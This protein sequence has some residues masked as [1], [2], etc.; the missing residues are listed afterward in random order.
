MR[1]GGQLKGIA[2]EP[3][4]IGGQQSDSIVEGSS[5][6]HGVDQPLLK[7]A[8]LGPVELKAARTNGCLEVGDGGARSSGVVR[9]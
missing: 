7:W 1:E 9:A 6:V 3:P 4:A 8:L 5:R 2:P